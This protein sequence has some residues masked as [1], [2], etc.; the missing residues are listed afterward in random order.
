MRSD[1]RHTTWQFSAEMNYRLP[2]MISTPS[3]VRQIS[4]FYALLCALSSETIECLPRLLLLLIIS[5][6]ATTKSD[7]DDVKKHT[8]ARRDLWILILHPLLVD[9]FLCQTFPLPSILSSRLI[10]LDGYQQDEQGKVLFSKNF[11][12][13]SKIC[14]KSRTFF[15]WFLPLKNFKAYSSHYFI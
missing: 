4:S 7:N 14:L 3:K 9:P 13:N 1:R 6:D 10:N 11:L 8:E 5:R 12:S 2:V 15:Y